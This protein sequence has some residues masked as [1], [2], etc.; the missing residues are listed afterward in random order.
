MLATIAAVIAIAVVV[1]ET[2]WLSTASLRFLRQL[3]RRQ[4]TTAKATKAN[5]SAVD[6]RP[7]TM[8]EIT[9]W[10]Y[11]FKN[12]LEALNNREQ[13]RWYVD[14]ILSMASTT[15]AMNQ[16]SHPLGD[17]TEAERS[18]VG[19]CSLCAERLAALLEWL[20]TPVQGVSGT[21]SISLNKAFNEPAAM[22]TGAPLQ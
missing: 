4:P 20:Q 18:H 1:W 22:S 13:A 14:H 5:P 17:L 16:S 7:W 15:P 8:E 11:G 10:L 6:S 12:Q 2:R 9:D 19:K 21:K 3:W